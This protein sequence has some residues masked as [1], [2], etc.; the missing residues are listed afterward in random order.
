MLLCTHTSKT[1][2]MDTPTKLSVLL[3][4]AFFL[5]RILRRKKSAF[6]KQ[7]RLLRGDYN[8]F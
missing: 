3:K 8:L 6:A 1:N 5:N 2:T 7:R 4:R